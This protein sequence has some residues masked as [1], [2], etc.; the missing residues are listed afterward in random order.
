MCFCCIDSI[1]CFITKHCF[2]VLL[3]LL[4]LLLL[5]LCSS[6][7]VRLFFVNELAVGRRQAF[8]TNTI[9]LYSE[10]MSSSAHDE[11]V[12]RLFSELLKATIQL[13]CICVGVWAERYTWICKYLYYIPTYV[14]RIATSKYVLIGSELHSVVFTS[15]RRPTIN[16]CIVHIKLWDKLIQNSI[17]IFGISLTLFTQYN[18]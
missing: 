4:L 14:H 2:T 16:F 10:Q 3:Y 6:I 18:I 15:Y 5:L 9:G 8:Y 11:V 12:A 1:I 7:R 17:F 13:T